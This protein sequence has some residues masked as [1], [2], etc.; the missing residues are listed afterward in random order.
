MCFIMPIMLW[1]KMDAQFDK[2]GNGICYTKLRKL[3]TV[4]VRYG[5]FQM[6]RVLDKVTERNNMFFEYLNQI[7]LKHIVRLAE[8]DLGDKNELDVFILI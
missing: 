6:S 4:D 3:P 5:N 1:T 8:S 7:S 2:P